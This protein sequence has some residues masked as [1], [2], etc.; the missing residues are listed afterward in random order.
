M[1][2]IRAKDHVLA[3]SATKC[4]R[5]FVFGDPAPSRE[6]RWKFMHAEGGFRPMLFDLEADPFEYCDLGG[7]SDYSAIIEQMYD[8]LGRWARRPSQ[9]T[10][11]SDRDIHDM[12]VRSGRN[13]VLIGLYDEAETNAELTA[14]YTGR[15]RQDFRESR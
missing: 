6:K 2:P 10:T 7:D 12:R 13:G 14:K 15:A 11:R 9:R 1:F 4:R 8:R 3:N 5:H